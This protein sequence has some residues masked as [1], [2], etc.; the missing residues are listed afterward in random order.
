MPFDV[1]PHAN[2]LK[3]WNDIVADEI[4]A[5]GDGR[6][7]LAFK[8]EQVSFCWSHLID[9][10]SSEVLTVDDVERLPA[11]VL[12]L[13]TDWTVSFEAVSACN[14]AASFVPGNLL[15][16]DRGTWL[17]AGSRGQEAV[18]SRFGLVGTC[19]GDEGRMPDVTD[20]RTFRVSVWR[21]SQGGALDEPFSLRFGEGKKNAGWFPRASAARHGVD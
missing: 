9:L 3:A 4:V 2:A 21:M 18:V 11:A 8:S 12:S 17:I 6:L 19:R 20:H 7:A 15:I 10:A 13:G 14:K 5:F 16:D 1:S